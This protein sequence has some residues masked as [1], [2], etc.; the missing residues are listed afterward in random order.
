MIL[1]HFII[2]VCVIALWQGI[3]T[4]AQLPIYLL[5]APLDV[6]HA[7]HKHFHL[8]TQHTLP[9]FVEIVL[10]L[11]LGVTLGCVGGIVI[12]STNPLSR[13]CMP[14][15]VISQAVPTFA[16]APLIV[17]WLGYGLS[18]KMVIIM[19]MIFFPVTSALYDGLTSTPKAWLDLAH[20]LSASKYQRFMKIRLPAAL[21]A[22][23]SGIRIA[24]VSAPLGAI[25]GE[26]VGANHGLGYLM[27]IANGR[28]EIDLMFAAII[29]L[30]TM[31]LALYLS[32]DKTL[33][34][35]IWW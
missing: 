16:L 20:S 22:A 7:F 23:A 9:T 5:P 10:G 11:L 18:A 13:W 8:L 17:V 3:V 14:I 24:A 15:L 25:I 29:V 26:W 32:V 31:A 1:R 4:I 33:K 27:V 19:L 30:I 21:P 6:L 28:M 12:A 34:Y 2:F 35:F